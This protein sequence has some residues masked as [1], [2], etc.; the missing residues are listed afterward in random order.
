MRSQLSAMQED[1]GR[2]AWPQ[3]KHVPGRLQ[4]ATQAPIA[5]RTRTRSIWVTT[6]RRRPC[7]LCTAAC[8]AAFGGVQCRQVAAGRQHSGVQCLIAHLV[9]AVLS[10]SATTTCTS[11]LLGGPKGLDKCLKMYL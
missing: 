8:T 3:R 10:G 1:A 5:C 11:I 4:P 6:I 2:G 7:G 9:I